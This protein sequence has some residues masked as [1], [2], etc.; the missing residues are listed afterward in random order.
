MRLA[1]SATRHA[2]AFMLSLARLSAAF[3]TDKPTPRTVHEN[4]PAAFITTVVIA[5]FPVHPARHLVIRVLASASAR[6]FM[7]IIQNWPS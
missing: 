3:L 6:D 1:I 7:S 2:A 4:M 5:D